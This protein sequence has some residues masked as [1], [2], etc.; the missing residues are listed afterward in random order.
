MFYVNLAAI[1]S[2]V[3]LLGYAAVATRR[4]PADDARPAKP[5]S[6]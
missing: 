5:V 4:K 6:K 1:F 2:G 3:G